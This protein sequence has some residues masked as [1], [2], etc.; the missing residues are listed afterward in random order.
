MRSL[1]IPPIA[2]ARGPEQPN[3][4]SDGFG[5]SSREAQLDAAANDRLPERE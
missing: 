5:L 2:K 1:G 3:S 4:W